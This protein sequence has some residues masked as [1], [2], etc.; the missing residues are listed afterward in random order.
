MSPISSEL[1]EAIKLK[2]G[3][4]SSWAI[5]GEM[6]PHL[7]HTKTILVGYN[8][9]KKITTPFG[10]FHEGRN[11]YRIREAIKG[12]LFEGSYMTDLIKDFEEKSSGKMKKYLKDNPDFI[13]ENISSFV[14]ELD[15]IGAKNP[16]L[17][18]FGDDCYT[19]LKKYLPAYK[20]FKLIHYSS[21]TTN[22]IRRAD[23]L[24]TEAAIQRELPSITSP[25]PLSQTS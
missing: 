1:F 20:I 6:S 11:D 25:H 22:E 4:M 7:L 12:T 23:I 17:V 8:I 10:N 24:K 16:V 18:A 5:W 13:T 9:S 3:F 15:F 21:F 2:Y 19:L 14:K